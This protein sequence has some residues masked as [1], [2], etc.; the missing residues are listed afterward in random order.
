MNRRHFLSSLGAAGLTAAGA[1]FWRLDENPDPITANSP[2]YA[3]WKSWERGLLQE[4]GNSFVWMV[5][6][7][8]LAASPHNT[9]PW[10][11]HLLPDAIDVYADT[12]RS[13]GAMDP[14]LREMYIGVGCAL[15]NLLLCAQT[16]GNS[17]SPG[18]PAPVPD[19]ALRP[20]A[21]VLAGKLPAT[22]HSSLYAAIPRR[23]T[24]RGPYVKGKNVDVHTLEALCGGQEDSDLR[25]FWFRQPEEKRACADLV[26][27]ATEAIIADREQSADSARW[28]RSTWHEIQQFRD[29]LTYDAQGLPWATRMLAKLL[30]PLSQ[31]QTAH[32]WLG[33]TR[34]VQVA[35][36][37]VFGIIA[38]RD[39]ANIRQRVAAGCLWQRIHLAATL[40]DIAAQPLNQPLERRDRELQL[41]LPPSHA[42][43]LFNLQQNDSWQAVM[44][45]RAGYPIRK[46]LPS[47]RRAI[48]SAL[49]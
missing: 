44:L 14:L 19:G 21:R 37:S 42:K 8:V 23:H 9:Q 12:S 1:C 47:P 35:T 38:V 45:F 22:H 33:A 40:L 28:M 29:G 16:T 30:P 36:A 3:P 48:A 41:G 32:Y 20:V 43:A 34:N 5:G 17:G 26:V 15:Q 7:A 49:I 24:N 31:N 11:F 27:S 13:L 10:K 2:A 4:D 18:Q 25:L 46:S 39:A 6:G